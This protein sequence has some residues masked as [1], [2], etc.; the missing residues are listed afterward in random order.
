MPFSKYL[1]ACPISLTLG[2]TSPLPEMTHDCLTQLN[3]SQNWDWFSEIQ[4]NLATKIL[5]CK[6]LRKVSEEKSVVKNKAPQDV[7]LWYADCFNLKTTYTLQAQ[8]KL[9]LPLNYLENF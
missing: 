1:I 2:A 5:E 3:F 4:K 8:E 7:F 6:T 9:L